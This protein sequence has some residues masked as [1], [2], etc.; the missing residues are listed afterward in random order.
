M[1]T[2]S[3]PQ[4][5][6]SRLLQLKD[7]NMKSTCHPFHFHLEP[8]IFLMR[9]PSLYSHP[10]SPLPDMTSIQDHAPVIKE[11]SERCQQDPQPISETP[12]DPSPL[13]LHDPQPDATESSPSR[14]STTATTSEKGAQDYFLFHLI[15]DGPRH[16][17]PPDY[18]NR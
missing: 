10:H 17:D 13:Q 8:H 7:P 6:A 16:L 3:L 14:R 18:F 9:L 15:C 11:L 4:H 12:R 5:G 1:I 2:H